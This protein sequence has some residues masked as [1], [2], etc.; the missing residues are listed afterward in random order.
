MCHVRELTSAYCQR[1]DGS[2][3][4]SA[5]P[6][7]IHRATDVCDGNNLHRPLLACSCATDII[8]RTHRDRSRGARI[9]VA[10]G[11]AEI[12]HFV[13]IEVILIRDNDAAGD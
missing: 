8:E 11:V 2:V 12:L 6:L 4:Q 13:G 7:K 5:V 3:R 1:T 9:G 10:E